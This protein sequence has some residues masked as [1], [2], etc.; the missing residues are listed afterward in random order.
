MEFYEKG[1]K[2][3]KFLFE[4]TCPAFPEQY[5]VFKNDEQV[6]YVRLR[7]GWLFLDYPDVGQERLLSHH[8]ADNYQGSFDNDE[9]RE[10]WLKVC[11]I[12]LDYKL[13]QEN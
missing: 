12:L 13:N 8:F 10:A 11:T 6:G 1:Y 4:L 9:Q 5:D 2:I 3:D 7:H